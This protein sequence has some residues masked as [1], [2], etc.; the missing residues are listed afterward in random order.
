MTRL[1]LK[2]AAAALALLGTVA[3]VP[4]QQ[5]VIDVAPG[6]ATYTGVA[7][8]GDGPNVTAGA[9]LVSPSQAAQ[10]FR[11]VCLAN[12]NRLRAAEVLVSNPPYARDTDTRI[13]YHQQYNL[14]FLITREGNEAICSMVWGSGSSEAAN[15]SA[16]E[17]TARDVGFR[18]VDGFY[19]VSIVGRY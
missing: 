19:N 7:G 2:A 14:S 5:V 4:A 17:A 9:A 1:A 13:E 3:C 10:F 11:Q 8:L 12:A 6:D 16:L 18:G 15:R